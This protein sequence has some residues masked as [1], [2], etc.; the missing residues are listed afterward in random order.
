LPDAVVVLSVD[1]STVEI[2][3]VSISAAA[4]PV[5]GKLIFKKLST[6]T[7]QS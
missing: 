7:D 4:Q 5:P 2:E 6:I 1:S 3:P